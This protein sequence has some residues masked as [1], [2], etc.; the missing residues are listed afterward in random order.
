MKLIVTLDN[1][2]TLLA[3]DTNEDDA[4][5][6]FIEENI[7][8]VYTAGWLD[9]KLCELHESMEDREAKD[10]FIGLFQDLLGVRGYA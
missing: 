10:I 6:M 5:C 2:E 1:L 3:V 9:C 7:T 8:D 4:L